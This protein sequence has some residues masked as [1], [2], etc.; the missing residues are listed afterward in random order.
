MNW[1]NLLSGVIGALLGGLLAIVAS[2]MSASI[3]HNSV[4]AEIEVRSR[5]NQLKD[6][7]EQWY[8]KTD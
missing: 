4:V 5:I 2:L 3:V 6:L 1:S 7:T 8:E